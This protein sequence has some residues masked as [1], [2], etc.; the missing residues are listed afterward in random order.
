[1]N[2]ASIVT[3]GN[4]ILIG[5]TVN[6]NASFLARKLLEI[7]IFVVGEHTVGDEEEAIVETFKLAAGEADIIVVTGGLGP[8]EDDLTRQALAKFLGMELELSEELLAKVE[9]KFRE[10][11]ITMPSNNKRQAYMP[12]GCEAIENIIGTAEGIRAEWKGRLIFV[13][14]GV[15][16]EM[17]MMFEESILPQI[18]KVIS[19]SQDNFK[20]IRKLNCFGAGES[21]IAEMLACFADRQRNPQ[22]NY[23]VSLGEV[24][25]HITA[26]GKSLEQAKKI[27]D[28][29]EKIITERLGDLIYSSGDLSL[30][31]VVGRELAEKKK[32]IATAESCTGGLLAKMI[33]DIAGSSRYFLQGWITYSNSTKISQLGVPGAL[34]DRFGA[35]SEETAT[36][37]AKGARQK[38][39]T[40]Y[41]IAITGIAGPDGGSEQ[42]PVGLVF[43][44]IDSNGGTETKRFIFAGNR[45]AIR[46]RA[47]KTALNMLRLQLQID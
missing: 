12:S 44:G 39:G 3:I 33:T 14:P 28:K 45:E 20:V 23:T 43:I 16:Y 8:T 7:G 25:I 13:M 40:D 37:M 34:I 26:S 24:N 11:G 4:E 38:A 41:T 27:A 2:K 36:A 22:I 29:D 42:K 35:V 30:E 1:M 10:R 18:Q 6:T 32:T 47:A 15:P 17:K 9:G 5:H 46:I 21:R 19:K 31:E